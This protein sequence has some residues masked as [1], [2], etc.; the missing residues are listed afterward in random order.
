MTIGPKY[1]LRKITT[2]V[3]ATLGF[4]ATIISIYA[5]F[6][7]DK[8]V[9]IQYEIVAN[10]NVLDINADV[11]RLDIT[12]NG[13]SLKEKNEHLRIINLRIINRGTDNILKEYFDDND[14]LGF[15][16][17]KGKLIEK[18][19][20]IETS[21]K[22]LKD[23]LKVS[24]DSTD[25]VMLPK[26]IIEPNES[27][28]LK[29]LILH[30]SGETP[31]IVPTGKVAGMKEYVVL[32]S[33]ESKDDK[34]FFSQVFSGSLIVQTVRSIAYFVIVL[35]FI[36]IIGLSIDAL[37]DVKQ[38]H[39]REQLVEDFKALKTYSYSKMDDAI[40]ER[41][42]NKDS[43]Q[44]EEMRDLIAEEKSLNEVYQKSIARLKK[45]D[46]GEN[47]ETD[48]VYSHSR[49]LRVSDDEWYNI[50]TMFEDGLVIREKE[51]LVINQPM[52]NTLDS[53][54]VYLK[55]KQK[56]REHRFPIRKISA[57]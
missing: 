32:N 6:F 41:Y 5:F 7:Q 26:V 30:K 35:I 33:L 49:L 22:Y 12:Y 13:L 48:F 31:E 23:N 47:A 34:P 51:K 28:V 50:N 40:F 55:E 4:I 14:P 19:E 2:I 17:S 54:L 46:G 1:S 24:I 11:S 57:A 25:R 37:S 20:I 38:K 16:I 29:L 56:L 43:A 36:V 27:F 42:I 39:N 21:S 44:L 8:K 15:R 10:T 45:K 53:F 52:K 3:V 9:D 18:P